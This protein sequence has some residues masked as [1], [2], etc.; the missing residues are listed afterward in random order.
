LP[1]AT[2]PGAPVENMSP[3]MRGT[4]RE[5]CSMIRGSFQIWSLVF[6]RMRCSPLTLQVTQMS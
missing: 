3:G 1:T 6:T 5:K 2:P 4:R